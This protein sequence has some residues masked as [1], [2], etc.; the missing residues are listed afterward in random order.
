MP[1]AHI[2]ASF[3]AAAH[4]DVGDRGR[5]SQEAVRTTDDVRKEFLQSFS[6][7]TMPSMVTL[8]DF[9]L[10]Y[11]DV[12]ALIEDDTYF[13]HLVWGVWS[14]AKVDAPPQQLLKHHSTTVRRGHYAQA[15]FQHDTKLW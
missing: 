15:A 6:S 11:G 14:L 3:N 4:P 9:L 10:Y 8:D 5:Q 13:V 2:R 12:S 1:I 7:E